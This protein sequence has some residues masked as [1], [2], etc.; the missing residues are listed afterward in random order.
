MIMISILD[1]E[2]VIYI[3][4]ESILDREQ[5]LFDSAVADGRLR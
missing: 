5:V 2:Q 1:R 3:D 4:G